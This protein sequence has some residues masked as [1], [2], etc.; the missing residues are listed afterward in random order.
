MATHHRR[1]VL[2]EGS[3][4]MEASYDSK[5]ALQRLLDTVKEGLLGHYPT[6]TSWQLPQ[7]RLFKWLMLLP[8]RTWGLEVS[9]RIL[10]GT[11]LIRAGAIVKKI[12]QV[13]ASRS[14]CNLCQPPQ[15]WIAPAVLSLCWPKSS[16]SVPGLPD[17]FISFSL[18]SE[19]H[20]DNLHPHVPLA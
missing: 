19:G 3:D 18:V 16:W 20:T 14:H 1:D 8:P 7:A 9:C 4:S 15:P 2:P 5:R 17:G 10:L 12:S 11:I 6:E 13:S